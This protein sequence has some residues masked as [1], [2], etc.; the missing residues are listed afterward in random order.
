[1]DLMLYVIKFGILFAVASAAIW[2]LSAFRA[3]KTD[4]KTNHMRGWFLVAIMTVAAI[5]VAFLG[6]I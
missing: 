4:E 5:A 3:G 6:H 2:A 1:M